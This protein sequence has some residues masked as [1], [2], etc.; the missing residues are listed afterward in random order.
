MEKLLKWYHLLQKAHGIFVVCSCILLC[1]LGY[2][3]YQIKKCL[4][5]IVNLRLACQTR[6]Q[7]LEELISSKIASEEMT[8]FPDTQKELE[9]IFIPLNRNPSYLQACSYEFFKK[10][11]LEELFYQVQSE[12]STYRGSVS[13]KEHKK[14]T[15]VSPKRMVRRSKNYGSSFLEWPIAPHLFWLSSPFGQRKKKDGTI[16]F[17]YG[18]DLAALKGTPVCAAADGVV[19]KACYEE[20]YGNVVVVQH[21]QRIS[22]RY[23]H[24]NSVH[25]KV[26]VRIAKG[27]LLGKVGETGFIR[28]RTKDGSHLHFEVCDGGKR[29][30]P[31]LL[32]PVI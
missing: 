24:L 29:V 27:N 15:S 28:K 30:N 13:N 20:G 17:H 14:F 31:A 16:G 22:T 21:T 5:E 26:G 9:D 2:E 6:L 1:G 7:M 10:E 4:S 11:R 18:I 25:V 23:A 8:D 32:L 19:V 12:W 3:Y